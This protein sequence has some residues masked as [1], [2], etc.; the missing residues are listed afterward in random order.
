MLSTKFERATKNTKSKLQGVYVGNSFSESQLLIAIPLVHGYCSVNG[1]KR[2]IFEK[3]L[4]ATVSSIPSLK[5]FLSHYEIVYLESHVD[6][7]RQ[8]M[9]RAAQAITSLIP[10]IFLAKRSTQKS[11]LMMDDWKSYQRRHAVWDQ[12]RLL[13]PDG[14]TKLSFFRRLAAGILVD[15][16]SARGRMLVRK[17]NIVSAFLG[18]TVYSG[19]GLMAQ[20]NHLGVTIFVF[21]G[22]VF[23]RAPRNHDVSVSILEQNEWNH[24]LTMTAKDDHRGFWEKRKTGNSSNQESSEAAR[25]SKNVESTT[26]HNLILLHVFRDSPFNRID[27]TRVFVE[28]V[29]WVIETLRILRDSK[30]NWLIKTH[31]SA[32]RW[33]ENQHTWLTEISKEAFAGAGWPGNIQIIGD[34]YSNVELFRHVKR[35]V[36][37]NGTS[38]LE[39]ACWGVRPIVVCNTSLASL[40][41]NLVLKPESVES[42][43]RFLLDPSS[44]QTFRLSDSETNLSRRA[45]YILEECLSFKNDVGFQTVL[46]GDSKTV[47]ETENSRVISKLYKSIPILYAQGRNLANGS[48]RTFSFS[49]FRRE[50]ETSATKTK[51]IEL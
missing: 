40:D 51:P 28:Y 39:A 50:L 17:H 37:F 27:P 18:H 10:G 46:R 7:F 21:A 8:V 9:S 35:L 12:A 47:F 26:A 22:G 49:L 48:N 41:Q 5:E 36:T 32:K 42:Y 44:S 38:H 13:A 45:L 2:I 31:P 25:G 15:M 1:I 30:E 29:D 24:V 11:L 33:G 4:P 19:R 43:A 14:V 20:L 3:S 23:Y 34:E 16:A 6:S